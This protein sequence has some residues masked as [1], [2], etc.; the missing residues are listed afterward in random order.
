MQIHKTQYAD[1]PNPENKGVISRILRLRG[2]AAAQPHRALL[3]H[4]IT[5][6]Q[7]P[8]SSNDDTESAARYNAP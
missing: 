2:T 4:R 3:F 7:K 8:I 1:A 6:S 5:A